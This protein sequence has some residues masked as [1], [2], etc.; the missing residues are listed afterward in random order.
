MWCLW[1]AKLPFHAFSA[2][3]YW[4]CFLSH[5]VMIISRSS[6]SAPTN[7]V[8]LSLIMIARWPLIE[9]DLRR[10][11]RNSIVEQ[12]TASS[13][14][15]A[16]DCSPDLYN[17]WTKLVA[18]CVV[19]RGCTRCKTQLWKIGHKLWLYFVFHFSTE[20]T[21]RYLT[22]WARSW[23]LRIQY[24]RGCRRNAVVSRLCPN[25]CAL[26]VINNEIQWSW[27]NNT[28]FLQ[29]C[30]TTAFETRPPALITS[31]SS[32][33]GLRD[34]NSPFIKRSFRLLCASLT[35][36]DSGSCSSSGL[37]GS[38]MHRLRTSFVLLCT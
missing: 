36:N 5:P 4:S 13:R 21:E 10:T 2:K 18:C 6:R 9:K 11:C 26:R 17:K 14:W 3:I 27:G 38:S 1:S 29:S 19:E 35:Q 34:L 37:R 23:A 25:L 24:F 28:R 15:T 16:V 32:L 33:N 8:P 30:V 7:W 22:D 20:Y 31:F 12:S